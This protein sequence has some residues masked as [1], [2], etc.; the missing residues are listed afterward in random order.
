MAMPSITVN[1]NDILVGDISCQR[2]EDLVTEITLHVLMDREM[3][4]EDRDFNTHWSWLDAVVHRRVNGSVHHTM[5]DL[6]VCAILY[7]A[8]TA[9][10]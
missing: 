1:D 6:G 10:P 7:V 8:Y 9:C 5:D 4:P 2:W 3:S